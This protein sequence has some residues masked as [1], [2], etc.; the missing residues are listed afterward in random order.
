MH[1][2][3]NK[4]MDHATRPRSILCFIDYRQR[5]ADAMDADRQEIVLLEA[6]QV[7][8]VWASTSLRCRKNSIFV[9]AA[10]QRAVY[11]PPPTSP[12]T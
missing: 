2:D 7:D 5:L 1:F 3:A 6:N 9:R 8:T 12:S 4:I 10:V 11:A